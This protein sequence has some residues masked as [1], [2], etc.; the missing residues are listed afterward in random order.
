M[1]RDDP[2]TREQL[3]AIARRALGFAT[4]DETRINLDSGWSGN[5]RFA[6]SEITTSG[7]VSD[8]SVTVTSTIGRRRASA[9]TNIV[10]DA[11]LRRAVDQA[12][13]LARLSPEDPEIVPELGPQTHPQVN[14]FARSTADLTPES[15]SGAV[16]RVI[17]AA[18][19]YGDS[20][21][22]SLAVAGFL[23]AG[24]GASAVATSRGLFAYHASTA[25]NL[26][27]TAR[28]ADGTGS[29]WA[30]TGERDWNAIDAAAIG[31]RAAEKAVA[32]RN[33]QAIEPGL[34]TVIL[35]P[36]AV[37]D[38]IPLLMG[39]FS[40][41]AADEGR[42]PFAKQGGGNMI[43]EKIADE[44]VTIYSDPVELQA[45]PFGF[46][47]SP[48]GRVV[49]VENGILRTLD[50]DRYW[51]S[52]QGVEPTPSGGGL[53]MAGGDASIDDLIAGADRAILLTR[54]WYIRFL[55]QRTVM[56]TGLTRDGTFLV[57]N[58][59]IT[60]SLKNFRWNDSPLFLLNRIEALGRPQRVSPST[61]MPAIRAS[62]FRFTSIS[63]AV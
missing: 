26:S 21:G 18:R 7:G 63:D 28:S 13:R 4:A 38:L 47:G 14:A 33:P 12:E 34:Y 45:Q 8:L 29:G 5:T 17:D 31:R 42:S 36:Q 37:A 19:T 10:D 6:V 32:S 53:K 23:E 60:R 54:L 39:S 15:R 48:T 59:R 3:Q 50:Y 9:T 20:S 52:R 44:R 56:V 41:R 24:T 57:E 58:G 27:A 30:A 55:D 22:A 49:W 35:E 51:A 11:G 25:V 1:R 40:A 2:H 62:D 61:E 16:Q 46:D 43:G